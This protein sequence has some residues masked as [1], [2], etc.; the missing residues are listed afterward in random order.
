MVCTARAWRVTAQA[1][2]GESTL[3]PLASATTP[4]RVSRSVASIF[5][6]W[7]RSAIPA[8]SSSCCRYDAT[9]RLSSSALS[10]HPIE[11]TAKSI[12]GVPG[13]AYLQEPSGSVRVGSATE[14]QH[15]RRR[16]WQRRRQPQQSQ[17]L[18]SPSSADAAAA[19]PDLRALTRSRRSSLPRPCPARAGRGPRN[20]RTGGRNGRSTGRPAREGP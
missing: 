20:C 11:R 7:K 13:L 17:H 8:S 10:A 14:A 6:A 19:D 1:A 18:S 12:S 3:V 9:S 4:Q 5:S 16:G 15:G 2:S